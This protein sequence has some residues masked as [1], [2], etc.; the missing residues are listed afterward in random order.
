MTERQTLS[1]LI[2]VIGFFAVVSLLEWTTHKETASLIHEG[3]CR[4]LLEARQVA[5]H[6]IYTDVVI[7]GSI[8]L[9]EFIITDKSGNSFAIK[10]DNSVAISYDADNSIWTWRTHALLLMGLGCLIWGILK[11]I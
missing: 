5:V 11:K 9:R 8:F 6:C 3:Q 2:A 4:P 1:F 10:R 7:E